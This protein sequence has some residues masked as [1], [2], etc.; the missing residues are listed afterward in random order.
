MSY[1]N[2]RFNRAMLSFDAF[3]AERGD[4]SK[5][6]AFS[7]QGQ[8]VERTLEQIEP[9]SDDGHSPEQELAGAIL[10]LVITGNG[11]LA[12]TLL[13]IAGNGNNRQTSI[14]RLAADSKSLNAARK[15]YF[16][17]RDRLISLFLEA[18]A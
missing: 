6:A 8:G 16:S 1:R 4:A 9:K 14:N 13:L 10:R 12:E 18:G 2:D 11:R 3:T 5:I 15:K 7:D 17:H